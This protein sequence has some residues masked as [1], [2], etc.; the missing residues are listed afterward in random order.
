MTQNLKTRF[1]SLSSAAALLLLSA[2]S[3]V[4]AEASSETEA[5]LAANGKFYRALNA[6]FEGNP[7][8]FE[9]VWWHTDDIVYMGAD[10]AYSVGWKSIYK[11]WE[12]QA[13]LKIGGKAEPKDVKVFVS[14]DMAMTSQFTVGTNRFDGKDVPVKL[15]ATSVFLKKDGE[16][17]IVRH[18][19]DVIGDLRN[20]LVE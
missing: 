6:M 16:W 8:P 17:R 14:G 7:K 12:K 20:T 18:H 5:V 10:G 4:A 2:T 9:E 13:K 19:V 3:A 11:N 15:R 1:L